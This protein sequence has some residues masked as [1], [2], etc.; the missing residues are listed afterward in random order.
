MLFILLYSLQLVLLHR[1]TINNYTNNY[2]I[3]FTLRSVYTSAVFTYKKCISYLGVSFISH[4]NLNE[5]NLLNPLYTTQPLINLPQR[6]LFIVLATHA[7]GVFT[8]VPE[9]CVSRSLSSVYH[10]ISISTSIQD[11]FIRYTTL[12]FPLNYRLLI[13]PD[14]TAHSLDKLPEILNLNKLIL[15]YN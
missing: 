5:Y 8:G 7:S 9:G 14:A 2:N 13:H 1:I 4:V 10:S 15:F 11:G 12:N 6:V 3:L